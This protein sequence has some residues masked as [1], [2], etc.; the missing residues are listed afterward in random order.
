MGFGGSD[1]ST[2]AHRWLVHRYTAG[3]TAWCDRRVIKGI[4]VKVEWRE[5]DDVYPFFCFWI[6]F[7]GLYIQKPAGLFGKR[8]LR[9]DVMETNGNASL[10]TNMDWRGT[11]SGEVHRSTLLGSMMTLLSSSLT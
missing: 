10:D 7:L 5:K 3:R 2:E 8:I 4:I 11:C 9:S 1:D 6:N